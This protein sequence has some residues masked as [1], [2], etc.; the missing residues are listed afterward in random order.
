MPTIND[1]GLLPISDLPDDTLILKTYIAKQRDL[2]DVYLLQYLI[3]REDNAELERRL[4]HLETF[5]SS[6]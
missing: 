5:R 6:N 1:G 2:L 4:R 3:L